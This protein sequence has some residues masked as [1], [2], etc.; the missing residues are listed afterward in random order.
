MHFWKKGEMYMISRITGPQHNLLGLEFWPSGAKGEIVVEEV[1]ISGEEVARLEA[2]AVKDRVR[3]G[4]DEAN[5][6]YGTSLQV[7]RMQFV[8]SD[9][10]SG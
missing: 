6:M 10:P 5:R 4:V 3:R 2:A 7:R 1:H 9:T 8:P